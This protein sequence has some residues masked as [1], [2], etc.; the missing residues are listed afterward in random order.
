MGTILLIIFIAILTLVALVLTIV[1]AVS[2][3][4]KL[5]F[6]SIAGFFVCGVATVLMIICSVKNLYDSVTSELVTDEMSEVSENSAKVA[7][8]VIKGTLTGVID[9]FDSESIRVDSSVVQA[10]IVVNHCENVYNGLS[11]YFDFT[12][13]FDG[14]LTLYAYDASDK[15]QG[16]AK[17]SIH[18]K[19]G[20]EG[21]HV[22]DFKDGV[23]SGLSGYYTLTIN[24]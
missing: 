7:G 14:V 9:G 21:V 19:A 22:F 12:K 1:G 15:K 6:G 18:A 5:M 16:F 3:N 10:G 8:K 11:I 2:K 23:N 4:K 17:D 24:P 13:D 20:D